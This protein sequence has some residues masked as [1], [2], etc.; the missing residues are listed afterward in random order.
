VGRAA[1]PV[2]A[3][4]TRAIDDHERAVQIETAAF[5]GAGVATAAL[6]LTWVLW[7]SSTGELA[8]QVRPRESGLLLVAGGSF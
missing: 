8:M 5:I 6:T 7:P 4:L 3:E 2:C 1:P